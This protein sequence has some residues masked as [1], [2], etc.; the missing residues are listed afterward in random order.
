MDWFDA[1]FV[2]VALGVIVWLIHQPAKRSH[3]QPYPE[4]KRKDDAE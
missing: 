1:G 3:Y 4:P 2:V